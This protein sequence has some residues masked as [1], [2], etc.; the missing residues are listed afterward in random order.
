MYFSACLLAL[1]RDHISGWIHRGNGDIFPGELAYAG[2]RI[3]S[4]RRV[5][6]DAIDSTLHIIPAMI[7]LNFYS[8]RDRSLVDSLMIHRGAGLYLTEENPYILLRTVQNLQEPDTLGLRV[9][10]P[11]EDGKIHALYQQIHD[12]LSIPSEDS[13][14]LTL[15]FQFLGPNKI[16]WDEIPGMWI[17]EFKALI[18]ETNWESVWVVREKSLQPDM[19]FE[20]TRLIL[21]YEDL[22]TYEKGKPTESDWFETLG[23]MGLRFPV[24]WFYGMSDSI[25]QANRLSREV[26]LQL[27]TVLPAEFLGID[28]RFG[29]LVPG[30]SAS[31]AVFKESGGPCEHLVIEG[32]YV[33]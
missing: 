9:L 5:P 22:K 18:Q 12:Y 10:I 3:I 28:L 1:P 11:N 2:N 23:N 6:I 14:Y 17:P 29:L 16:W 33:R 13:S 21:N 30:Y 4:L 24:S 26:F 15:P 20:N 32:V 8:G 31:F 19:I 7:D 27:T 25:L